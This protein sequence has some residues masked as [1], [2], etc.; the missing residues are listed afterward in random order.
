M[1]EDYV[2]LDVGIIGCGCS[3]LVT[4]KELLA[5]G[6]RCIVFEKSNCIGGLYT[7]A[8]QEGVFVSSHLLTMFGDFVGENEDILARPRMLSFVEYVAYLNAYAEHFCLKGSI[9]FGSEVDCLSKDATSNKWKIRV[10]NQPDTYA[11]DRIAICSGTYG[12]I[13][14]PSFDNEH[15]F[16][17]QIKHLKDIRSYEEFTGKHV[18]IVG[19]G[20]SASDMILA[21]AKY[22]EKAY[23]SIRKDH[24]FIVPR[25][26]HG[27]ADGPADLDTSRIHHSIPRAWGVLHTYIDMYNSLF[28]SYVKCYLYQQGQQNDYDRVRRAGIRMNLAQIRTSHVWNTFGTKNSNIVEALVRY[29]EKCQRKSGVQQLKAH[30]VVFHDGSEEYVD[31]IVCC[32]GFQSVFPYFDQTDPMLER[33]SI[34]GRRSHRLYKQ[35]FHPDLGAE[36]CWIGFARPALGAVPPLIELQARWFALLCSNKLTLPSKDDMIEQT[37]KYVQYLQWQLTPYRIQRL[38][39]L[40]DYL[41]YSD[42]L[43]RTIGCRPNFG[44]IFF[45][46]PKLWLKLMCGPLMNAQYRLTGPHAKP[47]QARDIL[48]KA[49]WVK[50]PNVLYFIM[51]LCYSFFWLVFGVES[52]KP[53]AWY[54]L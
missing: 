46:D 11:F 23:L 45:H 14:K 30:S 3:G 27:N 34:E 54:P 51:L 50:Q 36:L 19:S 5:E 21:A 37:D 20:E 6:H 35:C 29:P 8:Y 18:C 42:D 33:I 7:Q 53:A 48:L 22:G 52:C 24:G 9:R 1:S 26:I 38:G 41:I 40:T 49:K 13:S 44:Q 17:G 43:A 12:T 10:K 15:L 32:T 39:S 16:Q 47:A 2:Q 4:L 31:E 25:Y 28:K